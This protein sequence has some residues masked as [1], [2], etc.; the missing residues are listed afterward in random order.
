ME[1]IIRLRITIVSDI[2]TRLTV[3]KT[4]FK[5]NVRI[6]VIKKILR[7]KAIGRIDKS[8]FVSSSL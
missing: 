7:A 1:T 3:I 4:T 5:I 6:I 8:R 2:I